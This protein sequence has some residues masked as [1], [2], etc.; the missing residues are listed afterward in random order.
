MCP[1]RG[2]EPCVIWRYLPSVLI[3]GATI[4]LV[5]CISRMVFAPH[6]PMLVRRA[7]TRFCVPSVTDE[8]PKIIC[9]SVAVLPTLTL[10]P[11]GRAG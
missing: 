6:I 7:P 8:G 9:S 11:L 10:V 3:A 1:V 2:Y 4:I 5:C